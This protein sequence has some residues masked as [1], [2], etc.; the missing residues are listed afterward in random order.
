MKKS[1]F[2]FFI[3]LSDLLM[4]VSALFLTYLFRFHLDFFSNPIE[5]YPSDLLIPALVL[6]FYWLLFYFYYGLY[7]FPVA[8]SRFDESTRAV[9]AH[10]TGIIILFL[11]TFD[12][13]HPFALSRLTLVAYFIILTVLVALGRVFVITVQ[14][15]RFERGLG[16]SPVL[17]VGFN[18]LGFDIFNKIAQFKALGYKVHG[19]ITLNPDKHSGENYKDVKVLGGIDSLPKLISKLHIRELIIAFETGN[20]DRLLDVIDRVGRIDVGLKIIPD[21]YDIIS[22]QARTN[23][24]YGF[25]L[26]D[27]FPQLMPY[28]ERVIKRTMDICISLFAIIC[29]SPFFPFI[30]LAIK[31]DSRGPIFYLQ[32]RVGK[33]GRLFKIIKFRTMVSDAEKLTGPIW[34]QKNDP[35]ITRMGKF[36]RKT[37]IDEVPQFIN[38]LRN[39]MSLVGPRPERPAFVE[40][41]SRDIPLYKHRLKMKPGITGWAQIKH[42]YDESVEDVKTKLQ[43]DLYYLENMSL[44]LDFK[45]ILSTFAVMLEGK[46]Q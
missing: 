2:V 24:I 42:K 23:Q 8:P 39:E 30:A 27:I 12:L 11:I 15:R 35:R 19:F 26:I 3:M 16:L 10:F 7:Q 29:F 44:R 13:Y 45:I 25:P 28:W 37:R 31:L 21:M 4:T 17:I 33:R 5:I 14:R 18:E 20:H 34:S 6:Y 36:M 32:E 9:R 40:A 1:S 41:F 22:G 43:Y 38:I 46:G